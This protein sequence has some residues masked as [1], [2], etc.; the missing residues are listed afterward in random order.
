[1]QSFNRMGLGM[2]PPMPSYGQG[3]SMSALAAQQ[4][5][6][7]SQQFIPAQRTTTLFVGSISAGITDDFLNQLLDVSRSFADNQFGLTLPLG[8][9][10][11][12][13]LQTSHHASRETAGVWFCRVRD[14]RRRSSSNRV[15]QWRRVN[16]VG[17]WG[18]NEKVTGAPL[19]F[20]LF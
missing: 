16:P 1:M 4:Q 7:H 2:R 15:T 3:P 13:V 20:F 10:I 9:W 5:Q 12:E 19:I 18:S 11:S 14:A 8:L 17:G 6:I